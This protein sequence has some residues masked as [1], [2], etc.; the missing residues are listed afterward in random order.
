MKELI[1]KY[2]KDGLTP[3]ELSKLRKKAGTMTDSEIEK[4]ISDFWFNDSIDTSLVSYELIEKKKKDIDTVIDRKQFDLSKLIRWSQVAAAILLPVFIFFSVYSYRENR[5]IISEEMIVTTGKAER[6][7]IT[8]PDGSIVSLNSESRLGYLPKSYNKKERAISFSGEGHFQIFH[9]ESTPFF[10]NA[11]GLQVK[12]LGTT[13]NLFV[14]EMSGT[15]VLS[16][17]EGRVLLVSTR[18]NKNVILQKNQKAILEHS[19]G[20]ITVITEENIQDVSAWRRGDM[21]FRN[22]E[23]SQIIRIIEENYNVTIKANCEDYL[24]DLFTGTLPINDLN[25]AL[26]IIEYSYHL[27]AIIKGKEI[28]IEAN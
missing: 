2:R 28:T 7:G 13:F 22:M 9:N 14:R 1:D 8:L 11:K 20:D 15:A 6:A 25:E 4:Y 16:L 21:I 26:E 5:L 23:L 3:K 12:V 19:T 27:K 24:S 10:I 18:S 17:E